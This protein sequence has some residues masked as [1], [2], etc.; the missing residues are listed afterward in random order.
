MRIHEQHLQEAWAWL[1]ANPFNAKKLQ[2]QETLDR[3]NAISAIIAKTVYKLN[4]D[5]K[6]SLTDRLDRILTHTVWGYVCFLGVLFM[7]FQAIFSWSSYPMNFVEQA[8]I[9]IED[10]TRLLLPTGWFS[11]L[12]VDGVLAGLS[13]IVVFVPQIAMLFFFIAILEDSGYM[14]RVSYI[15]DKLMRKLGLNGKSVIPLISGVACAV[16]AIMSTRTIQNSRE[17]LITIMITPLMSCSARIPVYT[18]L[19]SMVIP[20]R[21]VWGVFNLQGLMLMVLYLSGFIAALGAAWVMRLFIKVKERSYFIMELPIYRA[22]RWSNI[23]ISIIEKIKLFLFDAGKVI[24]A[25]SIILWLLS[26]FGPGDKFKQIEQKYALV[27]TSTTMQVNEHKQT[28]QSEKLEA[29]YAGVLGHWMEPAIKPL[30]FDWKIGIALVT[31]FAAREV[32]VGTMATIYTVGNDSQLSVREKMMA[33][34]D[35]ETGLPRYTLAVGLSLMF[36]YVFAMQCMSTLAVVYRET[37][38]WRWPVIQVLYMSGLAYL[39]SLIIYQLL[40]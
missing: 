33:E 40:K 35:P 22:P 14:A 19:I 25:I 34:K 29:S 28:M 18:L 3:Y 27:K 4:E 16:P 36:F 20:N 10:T 37:R 26:S 8:F 5:G 30:G 21:Y 12:L 1:R 11:S 13:G 15:M 39:S 24:I 17:R 38:N 31:S 7:M 32:F 6:Q 23:G 9:H 2:A